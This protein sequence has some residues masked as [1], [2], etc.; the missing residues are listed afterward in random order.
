MDSILETLSEENCMDLIFPYNIDTL[1]YR[2]V[3]KIRE[4]QRYAKA[5]KALVEE[6]VPPG[7]DRIKALVNLETIEFKAVSSAEGYIQ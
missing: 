5:M 2:H 1:D 7:K 4:I 6:K 3:D